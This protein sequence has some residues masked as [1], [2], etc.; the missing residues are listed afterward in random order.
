M[1]WWQLTAVLN[2]VIA[3]CYLLI[4]GTIARGLVRTG[5][6]RTNRLGLATALIFM[7]CALHHGSH[8]VHLLG[9]SLGFG[10]VE[11]LHL[12]AAF[13]PH[14]VLVD[15]FGAT[16]ALWYWS[17]RGRYGALLSGP[18]LFADVKER[19]RRAV[20]INDDIV[21]GLATIA[22]AAELGDTATVKAAAARALDSSRK[23]INELV[24]PAGSP[25][26]LGAG[27]LRRDRAAGGVAVATVPEPPSSVGRD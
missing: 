1:G 14:A 18:S 10:R 25:V 26:R 15:L 11:G 23:I 2:G 7:T 9:P 6:L 17:L 16:V 12:R 20:E 5:Q 8:T 19:Q 24:G 13:G 4:S 3:V 27:D 22:Y 21:Q